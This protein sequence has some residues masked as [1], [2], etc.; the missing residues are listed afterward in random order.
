MAKIKVGYCAGHAGYKSTN[1]KKYA[2]PGKRTP[3]GVPEWVYN[4]TLAVAFHNELATYENV[5]LKRFDDPTGKTDV[6]L[7]TRT[8]KANA[9]G[10]DYYFSFHHNADKG[11]WAN[12]TGVETYVQK[13]VYGEA[14][15]VAEIM[16]DELVD[17]YGLRD[18]GVKHSNLHITRETK[19]PAVLFEGGFMDSRIDIKKLNDAQ[20]L[21][22]AGKGMATAFAQYKK[23]KRK[24]S[25]A[26]PA[27]K[28]KP[29]KV[30]YR[31]RK[32]ANDEKTQI[33]AFYS[34]PSAKAVATE[35]SGYEVYDS[36]GKLIFDPKKNNAPAPKPSTGIKS[37]GKIKIVNVSSAA[38]IMDKPDREKAKNVGTVKKGATIEIAGSVEG[39]N[40]N[41]GYWE[42]IYKGSRAYVTGKF[43]DK[44]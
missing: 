17:A 22:N 10:A 16:H 44:L 28:P 32:S 2:T 6:P 24:K 41:S 8:D 19:M 13:G 4:N 35:Q 31:V 37:V 7:D 20:V 12:H 9:W 39:K 15:K 29:S 26:T 34:L 33:G 42:V 38:I 1:P 27:P 40:S 18:R 11:T 25:A 21:K 30:L 3:D 36:T 5:E 14:L 43:G 23:L